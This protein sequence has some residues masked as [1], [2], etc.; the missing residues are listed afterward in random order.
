MKRTVFI[1][2]FTFLIIYNVSAQS[3]F[4][5]GLGFNY[6]SN[7]YDKPHLY[8]YFALSGNLSYS[9]IQS[10]RFEL[11][12]EN[13]T[14]LRLSGTPSDQVYKSGFTMSFPLLARL[15]LNNI[16][17]YTGTGP[18]YVRQ[19]S[20]D[21][22]FNERESGYFLNTIIGTGF[23][24]KQLLPGSII[25]EYNIRLSYL[26]SISPSVPDGGIISFIVFL[27]GNRQQV[28]SKL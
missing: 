9:L 6:I 11:A 13:A 15:K 17:F 14:S 25:P 24:R 10:K 5:A 16:N 27:T 20:R 7:T 12:I 18:A 2:V 8:D 28:G 19:T 22:S 4:K 1:L 21:I 26:K 3:R 23:R